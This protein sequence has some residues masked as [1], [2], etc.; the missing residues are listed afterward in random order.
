MELELG[1]LFVPFPVVRP[2]GFGVDPTMLNC[3]RLLHALRNV[4]WGFVAG[5]WQR[6][7]GQ[8]TAARIAYGGTDLVK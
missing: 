7:S 2:L 1:L 8:A 3:M 6:L 5:L 4:A